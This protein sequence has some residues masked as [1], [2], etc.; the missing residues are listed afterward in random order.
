MQPVHT[1][2]LSSYAASP[3]ACP[4]LVCSLRVASCMRACTC[5][6]IHDT[7]TCIIHM[8]SSKARLSACSASRPRHLERLRGCCDDRCQI[9]L[10][11]AAPSGTT[12][13]A[14][15][16]HVSSGCV[17]HYIIKHTKQKHTCIAEE[18]MRQESTSCLPH[19]RLSDSRAKLVY[20]GQVIYHDLERKGFLRAAPS[21]FGTYTSLDMYVRL[22]M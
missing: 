22:W 9:V 18:R 19:E 4:E 7:C 14:T 10:F 8:M 21:V 6:L 2:A 5:V 15:D 16:R 12:V 13:C 1:R 11:Q 17:Q 3:H 20:W